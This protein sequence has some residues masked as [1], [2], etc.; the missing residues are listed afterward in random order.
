[1]AHLYHMH[2]RE[3]VLLN[4]H[5]HLNCLFA[6]LILFDERFSLID[7]SETIVL[8][9]LVQALKILVPEAANAPS[10]STPTPQTNALN[11]NVNPEQEE[12]PPLSSTGQ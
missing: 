4:L 7:P 12:P 2:F 10:S 6:H 1:M 11:S 3:V 9:D 5:A 8:A